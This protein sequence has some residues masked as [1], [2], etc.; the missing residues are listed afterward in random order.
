MRNGKS[1]EASTLD[2]A[3]HVVR[4]KEQLAGPE[5]EE[6]ADSLHNLGAVQFERGEFKSALAIHQRALSDSAST[7]RVDGP[8]HSGQPRAHRPAGDSPRALHGE[9]RQRLTQALSI[10]EAGA[11]K[12]PLALAGA[13]ELQALLHRYSGGYAVAL[14]LLER[15]Q[16]IRAGHAPEASATTTLLDVRGDLL[17]L[18]GDI[19]AAQRSWSDGLAL[20][21]RT[22]D[23]DHPALALFLRK[24]A[25][26]ADAFGNR[27]D[28]RRLLDRAVAIGTRRL[29]MPPGS[30]GPSERFRAVEGT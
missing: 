20:G 19:S 18:R 23:A 5:S 21:E 8:R 2:L 7:A 4:L 12:A 16:A 30:G 25:L 1:G 6:A 15:A 11:A 14:S 28:S 17:F 13:L 10:R 24:L 26:A 9:L 3:K 29:P 22:L 27:S